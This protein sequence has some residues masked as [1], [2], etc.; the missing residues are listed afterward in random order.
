MDF[1]TNSWL[2]DMPKKLPVATLRLILWFY[3][4]DA[5]LCVWRAELRTNYLNRSL[6][7]A[8]AKQHHLHK[9][10]QDITRYSDAIGFS[11]GW[12]SLFY[13]KAERMTWCRGG[14]V[15]HA[16]PGGIFA[17]VRTGCGTCGTCGTRFGAFRGGRLPARQVLYSFCMRKTCTVFC[18]QNCRFIERKT[19]VS[20]CETAPFRMRCGFRN[21]WDSDVAL[22]MF[23]LVQAWRRWPVTQIGLKQRGASSQLEW[24]PKTNYQF[25]G[26]RHNEMG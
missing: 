21:S 13:H 25:T 17:S 18:F 24:D 11:L 22:D 15:A 10:S 2:L 6:T 14:W 23:H 8:P 12:S 26:W 7:I 9:I 5:E 16:D 20:L 3:V 4:T 19:P 1:E